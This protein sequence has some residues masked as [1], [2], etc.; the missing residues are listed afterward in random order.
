MKNQGNNMIYI[1]R[2]I[3]TYL[4]AL[5]HFNEKYRICYDFGY[6]NGW[7]IGV[8][9]F[10]I[11]SGFLLYRNAVPQKEKYPSTV[12]YMASRYSQ[13]YPSYILSF[14]V[15]FLFGAKGSF[16]ERMSLLQESF[17][18]MIG[19]QSVGLNRGWNDVNIAAWYISA[20]LI[21]SYILF[22]LLRNYEKVTI[23]LLLP[24]SIMILY[25]YF[26]RYKGNLDIVIEMEGFYLNGALMRGF[27]DMA[28]G[29]V[30]A[31]LNQYLESHAKN[32]LI[33]KGSA[34]VGFLG[35]IIYSFFNGHTK[36]DFIMSLMLTVCVAIAFLPNSK[37]QIPNFVK[38]WS[39]ASL[40]IYL[41]HMVFQ[42]YIFP[43]IWGIP[44]GINERIKIASIYILVIT[45]AGILLTLVAAQ[46]K[47]I[48]L[49][50]GNYL[51]Y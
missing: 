21:C 31:R 8:E 14:L 28:L 15:T 13:I 41:I 45:F 7:Y 33:W 48:F 10:F 44:Q 9:F 36:S 20:L 25:S 49:K 3:F 46:L 11:V 24:L 2:I 22:F 35:I 42:S 6:Q 27:A 1:W 43:T 17:W 39:K 40:G 38:K 37:M 12:S 19:L 23:N 30:A 32:L 34:I 4:I 50:L 18:E 29:V 51:L 47:K 16:G 5:F 26:Y